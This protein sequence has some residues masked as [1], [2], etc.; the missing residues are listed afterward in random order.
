MD[1]PGPIRDERKLSVEHASYRWG[2]NIVSFGLMLVIIIRGFSSNQSNWDLFALV[3]A[4]GLATM[5]Y[6]AWHRALPR[7]WFYAFL[8]M[9]VV[10][11]ATVL[12][13]TS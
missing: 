1:D 8:G 10:T 12:F 3:I 7:R 2:Y 9:A 5:G 13:L 4:G 11:A 6:Q